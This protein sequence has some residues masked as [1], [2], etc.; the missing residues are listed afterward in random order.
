MIVIRK[1]N[2]VRV[3]LALLLVSCSTQHETEN[4]TTKRVET[5]EVQS[6][7]HKAIERTYSFISR[8]YK[9][10][11]LSFRVGGPIKQFD[12]QAGK[13]YRKG[14]MIATIDPRDFI[15]K[16]NE[17]EAVCRQTETE[18]QRIA[19]LYAQDNISGSAYEKAKADY[20]RAKAAYERAANELKD[21][22]LIAP[23]DGY[24]QEI[25][26]E[27]Y[28]EIKATVPVLSFI[29][30]SR[31]K[32]E[33][34]IPE[35]MAKA[36]HQQ[37]D[38][39]CWVSFAGLDKKAYKATETFISQTAMDNNISFLLTAIIENKDN[40]LF[41]GMSGEVSLPV[42][43]ASNKTIVRVPQT[44]VFQQA[45]SGAAVWKIDKENRVQRTAVKIGDVYGKNQIEILS[46]LNIGDRIVTS[47]I[48][49]LSENEQISIH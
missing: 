10:V 48:Y 8:P 32:I 4:K 13:F 38:M 49:T 12:A 30:L 14:E 31:I 22:Q 21:T 24:V 1:K 27:Q 37:K 17:T 43:S 36:F 33:A 45:S 47:G 19:N 39:P 2:L 44:A 6:V 26:I 28:Q 20:A 3:C 35:D 9:T 7:A 42:L 41:G 29:D 18:F 23:F 46:G 34:Y 16:K 5:A 15:I 25:K 40:S 11:E